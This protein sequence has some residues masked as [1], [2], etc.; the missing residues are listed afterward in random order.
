MKPTAPPLP[1]SS[2]QWARN[3]AY[4]WNIRW[5]GYLCFFISVSGTKNDCFERRRTSTELKWILSNDKTTV[6]DSSNP[7]HV[8]TEDLRDISI[9]LET[10]PDLQTA[11]Q[12]NRLLPLL[13]RLIITAQFIL[14]LH[15]LMLFQLSWFC[16]APL[17]CLFHRL[18]LR[19]INM[20]V[21]SVAMWS[22]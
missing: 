1:R 14:N 21:V 13:P 11:S 6:Q 16:S 12:G 8:T 18:R 2:W 5:R 19:Q 3:G 4:W 10:T 7:V 20:L 15:A 9:S 17:S 22:F